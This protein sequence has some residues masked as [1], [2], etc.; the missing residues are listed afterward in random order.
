MSLYDALK[1]EADA[2]D[3]ALWREHGA[4][5]S[6]IPPT[7]LFALADWLDIID[8]ERGT[9]GRNEVQTDLREWAKMLVAAREAAG[10]EDGR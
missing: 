1:A 7:R 9:I 5:L 2:R 8:R 4:R 10:K 6:M 3:A